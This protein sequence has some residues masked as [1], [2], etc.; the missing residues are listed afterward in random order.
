M[1]RDSYCRLI[2]GLASRVYVSIWAP[3]NNVFRH[4][5]LR[6][7]LMPVALAP[8][9]LFQFAE[10][11]YKFLPNFFTF[12]LYFICL[13]WAFVHE[14]PGSRLEVINS[15]PVVVTCCDVFCFFGTGQCLK[16]K[17]FGLL[18]LRHRSIWMPNVLVNLALWG[19]IRERNV[20]FSFQF[21]HL[22]VRAAL[23]DAKVRI[24]TPYLGHSL[25]FPYGP[26]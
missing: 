3:R 4:W 15:F 1:L 20:I 12:W 8:D 2:D 23:G 14:L 18:A 9:L 22:V 16:L 6:V 19:K 26:I 11:L 25:G 13:T 10:D 24:W 21:Y 17:M 7:H 5:M